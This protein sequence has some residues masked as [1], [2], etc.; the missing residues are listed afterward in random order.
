MLPQVPSAPERLA[1]VAAW[2]WIASEGSQGLTERT[3]LNCWPR[4]LRR[5]STRMTLVQQQSSRLCRKCFLL[6][7]GFNSMVYDSG[8]PVKRANIPSEHAEVELLAVCPARNSRCMRLKQQNRCRKC[9]QH[10]HRHTENIVQR[11]GWHKEDANA[12]NEHAAVELLAGYS[13]AQSTMHDCQSA[14]P[15]TLLPQMPSACAAATYGLV[16]VMRSH[17]TS[18]SIARV[19]CSGRL[20]CAMFPTQTNHCTNSNTN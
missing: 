3:A 10:S 14:T 12:P 20:A 8:A 17:V 19:S 1:K 11:N 7:H 5:N 16:H 4:L 15:V 2:R 13:A 9:R 18:A 6:A